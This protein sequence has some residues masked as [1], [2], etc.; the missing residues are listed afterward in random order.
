M[1]LPL[2]LKQPFRSSLFPQLSL[3]CQVRSLLPAA[4]PTVRRSLPA[5]TSWCATTA[6]TRGTWASCNLPFKERGEGRWQRAVPASGGQTL[7]SGQCFCSLFIVLRTDDAR[8]TTSRQQTDRKPSRCLICRKVGQPNNAEPVRH[9]FYLAFLSFQCKMKKML[10]H[11]F[12][13]ILSF[14]YCNNG[15]ILKICWT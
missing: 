2:M 6:C 7:D 11:T 5:L 8:D 3:F 15:F 14:F 12:V 4:G 1:Y 9:L 13:N 10:I